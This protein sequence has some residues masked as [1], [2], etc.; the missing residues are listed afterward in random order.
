[1]SSKAHALE[2]VETWRLPSR[3]RRAGHAFAAIP[4]PTHSG[5]AATMSPSPAAGPE[6]GELAAYLVLDRSERA[7]SHAATLRLSGSDLD[8]QVRLGHAR[9][10]RRGD[11]RLAAGR[12]LGEQSAAPF[13]VEL[14]EDVVEKEKR[15]L[16]PA[17]RQKLRLGKDER[18][19][20]RALLSLRAEAAQLAAAGGDRRVAEVR[21]RHR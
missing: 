7:E 13:G 18:E 1:M 3:A 4:A 19:D 8:D 9:F 5:H 11:H 12:K 21:A 10:V 6:A 2:L 16:A 17:I 15:R 20:G 14:A